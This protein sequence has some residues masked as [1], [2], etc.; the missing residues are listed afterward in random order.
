[1]N[2]KKI[3]DK[4]NMTIQ[5]EHNKNTG[6]G[7]SILKQFDKAEQ[8]YGDIPAPTKQVQ[9]K[10]VRVSHTLLPS[11]IKLMDDIMHRTRIRAN[12][13]EI[14]RAGLRALNSLEDKD[15]MEVL[16]R[17]EQLPHSKRY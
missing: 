5:A 4:L 11:D 16:S 12:K 13:S 2:S 10:V 15:L 14:I 17:I 6:I 8:I 1:M 7:Q 9:V 3:A